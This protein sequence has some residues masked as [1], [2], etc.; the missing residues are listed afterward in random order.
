MT[1][2][3]L[4]ILIMSSFV[5]NAQIRVQGEVIDAESADPIPY[6]SI[7]VVGANKGTVSSIDGTFDLSV[8][9]MF[10]DSTVRISMY[11]Y[12]TLE[13]TL[14]SFQEHLAES[15]NTVVF[16]ERVLEQEEVVVRAIDMKEKTLGK[17]VT[18]GNLLIQF[19]S[20]QLGAQIGTVVKVKKRTI[21][22]D[23]NF[24]L[25]QKDYDSVRYR[26]N[27]YDYDVKTDTGDSLI[28][29]SI[30]FTVVGDYEDVYVL[31]L[32]DKYIQLREDFIA[33]IEIVD[34][35]R[36]DSLET[37]PKIW[38]GGGFGGGCKAKIASQSDWLNVPVSAVGFFMNVRQAKRKE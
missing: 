31:D 1:R 36:G 16:K 23:F 27:F 7:G 26:L 17:E 22:E 14:A 8:D 10:A 12:E 35:R 19:L 3:I 24:Y 20:D 11:G 21:I 28:A 9:S 30:L 32:K 34:G 13:F 29:P 33:S 37:Q 38:F 18:N 25:K 6:A 4:P 2:L 5:L 15:G